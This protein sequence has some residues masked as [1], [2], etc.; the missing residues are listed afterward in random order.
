V[1]QLVNAWLKN[2][3]ALLLPPH[4]VLCGGAGQP[5]LLDLCAP[6]AAELPHNLVACA[7]CAVPLPAGAPPGCICGRCL[8]RPPQFDQALAPYHYAYPLDRLVKDL[9]YHARLAYGR[10]LG[11][12]LAQRVR[13]HAATLPEL[14]VPVPLFPARHR[15]RGFNQ[16]VEI[17]RH[18]SG[19]LRVPLGERVCRRVRATADQTT[20]TARE[21]RRNVRGAFALERPLR[22]QHVV[23]LDDVLTTGSTA[24]EFARTLKRAGVKEVSVWAVA[25]AAPDHLV[26]R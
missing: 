8:R 12:L 2:V 1:H 26:N 9:K 3:Q 4:C 14:I 24:N 10:I 16:S 11:T 19:E 15:E 22:L 21:R 18:V 25:R 23:I 13:T 20:L 5:P 7:R 17:A 6:C